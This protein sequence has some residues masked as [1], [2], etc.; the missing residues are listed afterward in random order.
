MALP[1][2][3]TATLTK[4]VNT[5]FKET[6][7]RNARKRCVHFMGTQAAD[8]SHNRGTTTATWR[9]I[10]NMA[11]STTSL[12]EITTASYMQGRN[13]ATLAISSPT[14]TALKYGEFIILTEEADLINFNG[15]TDKI[16]EVLSI[17][18]GEK[19]DILQRNAMINGVTLAFVGGVVN[20]GA[21]ISK[22]T[23]SAIK[24]Q[25]NTLDKNSALTFTPGSFNNNIG[26]SGAAGVIA[27]SSFLPSYWAITHPDVSLD[28]VDL[29]GFKPAETYAGGVTLATGEYGAMTV[30]GRSV[31]FVSTQNADVELNAGGANPGGLREDGGTGGIDTYTTLIYGQDA[32][33]SLGFGNMLPDGTYLAGDDIGAF[34]LIHKGFKDGGTSDVFEEISTLAYKGW[35]AGVTLNPNWGRGLVTGATQV[36]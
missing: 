17:N 14:A 2:T 11:V 26:G 24:A 3:D 27:S 21:V 18:G 34:K 10:E 30:G 9:R 7:L 31:R 12:T 25:V 15:Q 20:E 23:N 8:I 28:V 35:H 16:V 19:F 22:I 36:Q 6:L 13:A 5:I 32:F 1:T 33:G 4:P 29:N